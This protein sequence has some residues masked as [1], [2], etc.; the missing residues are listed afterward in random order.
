MR[1]KERGDGMKGK[2]GKKKEGKGEGRR[3]EGEARKKETEGTN[4][5]GGVDPVFWKT[6]MGCQV[7][8]E[9]SETPH[10][11]THTHTHPHNLHKA[12]TQHTLKNGRL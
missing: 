9:F 5:E 2:E 7:L 1:E 10:L 8:L 11:H 12:S 3:K 6:V 4:R